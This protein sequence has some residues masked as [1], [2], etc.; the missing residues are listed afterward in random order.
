MPKKIL[1]C[2]DCRVTKPSVYVGGV[3]DVYR[4][5]APICQH[6]GKPMHTLNNSKPIPKKRDVKGWKKF[7]EYHA[8]TVDT[9]Q[10]I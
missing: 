1:A 7:K 5:V 9:I 8:K 4:E 6:C 3:R 10:L 2:F